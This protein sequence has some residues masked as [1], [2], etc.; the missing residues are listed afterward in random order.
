MPR[1]VVLDGYCLNPG[2][3]SWSELQ[4]LGDLTVYDRTAPDQ[5]VRRMGDAPVMI[6]NKCRIGK[7]II[8]ALPD[9]RYIGVLA[10]GYDVIDCAY[11][12]SKGIV[13]TNIP[14]YSTDSVVQ[15]TIGLMIELTS[16]I[17]SQNAD[18]RKE[19]PL[20]P[21]YCYYHHRLTELAGKT[22]GIVGYGR[23]GKRVRAVAEALG[24]RV[25]AFNRGKLMVDG[26][27]RTTATLRE[28]LAESDVV[29]LNCPLN[30]S[31]RRMINAETIKEMKDGAYLINTARG[32]L[33]DD[34]ALADAL[35]SG[36][37]AGAG[38]DVLST[39]PPRPDN[40]LLSAPGVVLTPHTAWA[41]SE[42]R[43]RL[44]QIAVDNL[45]AFLQGSPVNRV[46]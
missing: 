30:D 18:V 9:L 41:T 36:K 39:E 6:T 17:G 3:L 32:G 10:T 40:P 8:D 28:L 46:N 27:F 19:W 35:R 43:S 13:V 34:D 37:L 20:C 16:R 24:M 42:A 15:M 29:S 45:R 26:A 23:I 14:A 22:L 11:A 1:I 4:Q 25:I 5:I 7:E 21:D 2:D 44:M 31:N 38:L 33:I 12:A